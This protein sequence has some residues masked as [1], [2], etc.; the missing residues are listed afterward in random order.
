M[1]WIRLLAAGSLA[2]LLSTSAWAQDSSGISSELERT[3]S[4]T[5][6]QKIDYAAASTTEIEE[7]LGRVD[8][9][10]E[11]LQEDPTNGNLECVT[12]RQASIR[13]LL[14]VSNTAENQMKQALGILAGGDDPDQ[15]E[16]AV[17]KADHEF[18]KIAV[19]VSKTRMLLAEAQRCVGGEAL[20]DGE[21]SVDVLIDDDMSGAE[22]EPSDIGQTDV[23]FDPP[24]ASPF[25]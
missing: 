14:S 24:D 23:G 17:D 12:V 19:A 16:R 8:R 3:A 7:A 1:T 4:T 20:A 22:D 13:A 11:D 5:P 9:L 18:R 21:V 6:A 2:V 15:K 10:V 25:I